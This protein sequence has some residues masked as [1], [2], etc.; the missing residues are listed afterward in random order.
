MAIAVLSKPFPTFLR[1]RL[2]PARFQRRRLSPARLSRPARAAKNLLYLLE[3]FDHLVGGRAGSPSIPVSWELHLFGDGPARQELESAAASRGLKS[4]VRFHGTVP[5]DAVHN[6]IDQCHLFASPSISE[7][8]CVAAL[9]ILSRGRPIVA[10]PVGAFPEFMTEPEL[11][12][13]APLDDAAHFAH[14]LSQVGLL[15]LRG[16]LTPAAVQSRF[17]DLFAH[18]RIIDKY[19]PLFPNKSHSNRSARVL[20]AQ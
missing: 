7:E 14:A 15:L 18:D 11:G 10:T 6:A 17:A 20:A 12:Q 2:C 5:H 13:L 16:Q 9:E 19:C 3:A 8:Q 1:S 4:R